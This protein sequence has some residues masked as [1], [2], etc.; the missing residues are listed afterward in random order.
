MAR[1]ARAR[2]SARL[3]SSAGGMPASTGSCST[4]VGCKYLVIIRRVQLRLTS[5]RLVCLL[6]LRVGAQYSGGAYTSAMA[7]VMMDLLPIL[8]PQVCGWVPWP[9]LW[10]LQDV[11]GKRVSCQAWRQGKW[12]WPESLNALYLYRCTHPAHVSL[13]CCSDGRLL[14]LSYHH[15]VSATTCSGKGPRCPCPD[16]GCFQSSS[17]PVGLIG[18]PSHRHCHTSWRW[19]RE[20]MDVDIEQQWG[21]DRSLRDTVLKALVRPSTFNCSIVAPS[22][23]TTAAARSEKSAEQGSGPRFR[24]SVLT[25]VWF[26]VIGI[27]LQRVSRL[28][29]VIATNYYSDIIYYKL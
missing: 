21:Q 24:V 28:D 6:L 2:L 17:I 11:D 13:P 19:Y 22:P 25:L 26:R 8:Y 20:V 10:V 12:L 3:L 7:L 1:R 14:R 4:G 16:L 18:W 23:S 9:Y 27:S 15:S 29:R 5:S